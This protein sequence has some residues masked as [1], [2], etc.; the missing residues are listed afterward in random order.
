[1]GLPSVKDLSRELFPTV[2]SPRGQHM[3]SLSGHSST[4]VNCTIINSFSKI[5]SSRV[6]IDEKPLLKTVKNLTIFRA[7]PNIDVQS[8]YLKKPCFLS[9][10]SRCVHSGRFLDPYWS[11]PGKLKPNPSFYVP[12]QYFLLL[13]KILCMLLTKILKVI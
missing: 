6:P 13:S 8:S 4:Y 5:G 2:L 7:E 9:D 1:M 3:N 10:P 11:V 12:L